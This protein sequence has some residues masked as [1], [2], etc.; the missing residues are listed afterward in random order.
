MTQE[1]NFFSGC[2]FEKASSYAG[3][4]SAEDCAVYK[5]LS[6][7]CAQSIKALAI[8]TKHIAP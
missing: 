2:N 5:A 4:I 7:G 1:N 3:G 6:D 8:H